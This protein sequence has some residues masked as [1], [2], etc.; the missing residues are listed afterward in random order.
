MRY[1]CTND[2]RFA[3][4]SSRE[5]LYGLPMCDDKQ[6]PPKNTR[7][8]YFNVTSSKE[9]RLNRL[10]GSSDSIGRLIS[11]KITFTQSLSD[12]SCR[13]YLKIIYFNTFDA[14]GLNLL[15]VYIMP[16]CLAWNIPEPK[17]ARPYLKQNNVSMMSQGSD[18]IWSWHIPLLP[19]SR[20]RIPPEFNCWTSVASVFQYWSCCWVLSVL[21]LDLYV[22]VLIH[23]WVEVLHANRTTYIFMKH[24]RI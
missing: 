15:H 6:S 21:N 16:F 3:S 2:V 5:M 19:S 7:R 11:I 10:N 4:R 14:F 13:I 8:W 24:T 12:Y 23:W 22:A 18:A 1:T 9:F 17:H 20:T